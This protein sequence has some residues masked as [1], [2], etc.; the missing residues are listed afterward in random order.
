MLDAETRP[1]PTSFI[2]HFPCRT[3]AA[4]LLKA[5]TTEIRVRLKADTTATYR[6]YD[7]RRAA[8]DRRIT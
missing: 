8:A 5:D 6:S 1:N 7:S 4:P 3:L 2:L